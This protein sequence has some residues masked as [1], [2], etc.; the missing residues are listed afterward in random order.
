MPVEFEVGMAM[1]QVPAPQGWH[2]KGELQ[3]AYDQWHNDANHALA[4]RNAIIQEI[5]A[6]NNIQDDSLEGLLSTLERTEHARK[7]LQEA[8]DEVIRTHV[9]LVEMTDTKHRRHYLKH[10]E[11]NKFTYEKLKEQH[12]DHCTFLKDTIRPNA[13]KENENFEQCQRNVAYLRSAV[14]LDKSFARF[15]EECSKTY[16]GEG[17]P[18]KIDE[19]KG[20]LD[21]S[22]EQAIQS[23][24]ESDI[25]LNCDWTR[26]AAVARET[27][28]GAQ[29]ALMHSA[30]CEEYATYKHEYDRLC[31]IVCDRDASEGVGRRP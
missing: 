5:N 25:A 19:T 28:D 14:E 15:K 1:Q 27:Y 7:R 22:I 30:S 2:M 16:R 6:F 4:R 12:R 26:I 21:R 13:S 11:V 24:R 29:C 20:A 9:V 17:V 23:A 10:E 3:R 18:E 31:A 8:N